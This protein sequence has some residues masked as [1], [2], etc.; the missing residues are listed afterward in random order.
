MGGTKTNPRKH[1]A[2]E[3]A[4]LSL[5]EIAG[6]HPLAAEELHKLPPLPY[7]PIKRLPQEVLS[8]ALS[9]RRFQVVPNRKGPGLYVITHLRFFDSLSELLQTNVKVQVEIV[10]GLSADAIRQRARADIFPGA[11]ADRVPIS[12]L[13]AIAEVLEFEFPSHAGRGKV[14]GGR[15]MVARCFGVDSRRF[16]EKQKPNRK[17]MNNS[18]GIAA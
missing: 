18:R 11:L 4:L 1:C 15:A 7:L 2:G 10:R 12:A 8:R 17:G 14:M 3:L 5:R 16:K 6:I 13:A 9:V